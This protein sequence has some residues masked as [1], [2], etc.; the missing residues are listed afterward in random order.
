VS[1]ENRWYGP[2]FLFYTQISAKNFSEKPE[3]LQKDLDEWLYY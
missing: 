3:E 2:I 1:K